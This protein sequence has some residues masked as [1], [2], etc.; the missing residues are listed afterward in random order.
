VVSTQTDTLA[1]HA[2]PATSFAH[3]VEREIAR[4]FDEHGVEWLYEPRTFVLE[5]SEDGAVREAFT[6]DF[7]L[8]AFDVYIECT[9]L[10]HGLMSRKWRK[11]RKARRQG[12][13]VEV[14]GRRDI[15][16]LALRWQL[17]ELARAADEGSSMQ[18]VDGV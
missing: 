11:A 15:E 10:R 5:R 16:Q 18:E 17:G 1:S 4:I 9:V 8:P 7:Y 2:P 12:I 13:T 3:P 14:L 6:P